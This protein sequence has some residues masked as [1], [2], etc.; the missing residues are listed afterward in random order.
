MNVAHVFRS[1]FRRTFEKICNLFFPVTCP[2]CEK[3]MPRLY[4]GYCSDCHRELWRLREKTCSVCGMRFSNPDMPS[5]ICA[6]CRGHRFPYVSITA[7]VSYNRKAVKNAVL[8][9]KFGGKIGNFRPFGVMMS[10]AVKKQFSGV[11]FDYIT[12]I[13]SRLKRMKQRGFCPPELL[14]EELSHQLSLPYIGT[15]KKIR[16]TRHQSTLSIKER[17]TNL[18]DAFICTK[19]E[20]V[21]GK[22][23]LLVDDVVTTGSSLKECA[24]TLRRAGAKKVYCVTFARTEKPRGEF[25]A[26]DFEPYDEYSILP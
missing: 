8:S 13:P 4:P 21:S 16:D 26:D 6:D 2:F 23:I 24:K 22:T 9:F 7:P 3:P 1:F 11:P 10:L 17:R 18:K 20:Q 25:T 12:Y 14:A 15:L 5:P 19:P